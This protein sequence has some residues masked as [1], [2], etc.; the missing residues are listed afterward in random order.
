MSRCP[1]T[2]RDLVD[3]FKA[4]VHTKLSSARRGC[5]TWS[6]PQ[7]ATVWVACVPPLSK[8]VHLPFAVYAGA[9]HNTCPR[10][11]GP[12]TGGL[13]GH[14]SPGQQA[15]CGSEASWLNS[16]FVSICFKRLCCACATTIWMPNCNAV[17]CMGRL[18]RNVSSPAGCCLGYPTQKCISHR[19]DRPPVTHWIIHDGALSFTSAGAPGRIGQR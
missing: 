14:R 17:I 3:D 19:E 5:A 2:L 13:H 18:L 4:H 9:P 16:Q 1:A 11:R 8:V 12:H 10:A 6:L 15:P 7:R